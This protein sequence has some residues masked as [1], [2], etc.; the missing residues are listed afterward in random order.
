M[1]FTKPKNKQYT[2]E[3][4]RF[5]NKHDC[6]VQGGASKLFKYAISNMNSGDTIVSYN[7]ITKTSGKIYKTL[8]FSCTS[9]N[10]P[11]YIWMNF[12]TG[13]IR[14]RYQ[15]QAAGEVERMHNLGYHRICDCGTKTWLYIVK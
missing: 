5:C 12:T 14:T 8:D 15:E 13:D 9:I 6:I 3:L 1:T 2:W 7:D 11:N 4:S 10:S